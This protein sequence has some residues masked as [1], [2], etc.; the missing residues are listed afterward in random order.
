[1]VFNSCTMH[2]LIKWFDDYVREHD[3]PNL[4]WRMDPV[5]NPNLMR[6]EHVPMHLRLEAIEK[7]KHYAGKLHDDSSN[8][9]LDVLMKTLTSQEKPTEGS[10]RD[11]R[12]YT[13]VLDIKRKQNVLEVF[14]H[15]KEVFYE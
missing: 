6:I 15:L 12:E 1:M 11:L 9:M 7:L 14:P 8:E 3:L 2:R 4:K 10:D 13:K 5:T